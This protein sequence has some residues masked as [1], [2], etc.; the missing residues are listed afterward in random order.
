MS[1]ITQRALEASLKKLLHK[2]P[3]DEITVKDLVEDCGISRSAFYYHFNC[4]EDLVEW[5]VENDFKKII[6]GKTGVTTWQEGITQVMEE[7]YRDKDFLYNILNFMDMRSI[8]RSVLEWTEECLNSSIE[9]YSKGLQISE[10]DKKFVKR[11]YAYSFEG[12]VLDWVQKG[13][14]EPI[15]SFVSRLGIA[16]K[17]TVRKSL[18]AFDK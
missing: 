18:Q 9:E 12:M 4:I 15:S 1:E 6:E 3:I 11:L 17:G 13:M 7:L 10:N 8:Q 2:H 16:L 14:K 5:S